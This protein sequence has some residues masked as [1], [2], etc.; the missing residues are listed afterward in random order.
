MFLESIGLYFRIVQNQNSLLVTRQMTL[1]H[2]GV[3][4]GGKI[5][6]LNARVKRTWTH[7]HL[8]FH[9]T[10]LESIIPSY[11]SSG[12]ILNL[13]QFLL[14]AFSM[15]IPNRTSIFQDWAHQSFISCF[16]NILGARCFSY[17]VSYDQFTI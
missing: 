6:P 7:N 15:R 17:F 3:R 16:F 5:S 1:F 10:F 8:T 11:K 14:E 9:T 13:L 4:M 12:T 2:Q